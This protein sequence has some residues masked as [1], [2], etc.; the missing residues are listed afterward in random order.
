M[1]SS[2]ENSGSLADTQLT[3]LREKGQ[4]TDKMLIAD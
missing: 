2:G 3:K 1:V 4:G